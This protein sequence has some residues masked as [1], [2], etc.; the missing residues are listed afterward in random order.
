MPFWAIQAGLPME[1]P[2]GAWVVVNEVYRDF[3]P[4]GRA[5]PGHALGPRSVSLGS[6]TKVYGLGE[7]RV[8][9]MIADPSLLH[10]ASRVNDFSVV[11]GP[12]IA[13]RIGALALA[14]R[15]RLL[16]RT[17]SILRRNRPL[18]A[19]FLRQT[20][21]LEAVSPDG[22]LIIFPRVRNVRDTA[23]FAERA[24]TEHGVCVVPGEFFGAA[25]HI[26]IG[27]GLKDHRRTAEGFRRLQVALEAATGDH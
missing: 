13:E 22:G 14:R 27:I 15:T 6:L 2:A 25:G 9:W 7:T 16:A 1:V 5:V 4:K 26:R 24:L 21:S 19:R 11:N 12:Y 18:L 8:G 3:M 10:R 23:A 20:P 17:R